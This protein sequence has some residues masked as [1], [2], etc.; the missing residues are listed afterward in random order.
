MATQFLTGA[1]GCIGAWVLREL[2]ARGD[3]VVAF[4]LST[5]RHRIDAVLEPGQ[6][7]SIRHIEGDVSDPDAIGKAIESSRPAGIIHLA[8]M[9]VPSCKADP[10]RGA[11]VNVVGTLNV[12]EA[13]RA[14]GCGRVVYASSAAVY[15]PPQG[16]PDHAFRE[17]EADDARTHYGVF[18]QA[19]EGA[20]RVFWHDHGLSTVGLR[21]LTVYGV[22]R[23]FGLTS[24]PTTA[25]KAALLG[26]PY[27][28]GFTGP[29]DF[30]YV[31]DIAQIFVRCLAETPDGAHIYNPHGE[32]T[33]VS[34]IVE[35]I[36]RIVPED[37][38]GLVTCDGPNLPIPGNMSDAS[39]AAAM[40]DIPRT[41]LEEGLR[42][43]YE[44]FGA[45]NDAG[46]LDLRDLPREEV[47]R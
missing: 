21:P 45:L 28:I 3:E 16:D 17:D 30:Q 19:N 46:R 29:T 6:Q 7:A 36:D 9:Q 42:R 11:M 25:L 2:V 1:C 23:D 35:L 44:A 8:G 47:A 10:V 22:G 34:R 5:E 20:A 39:L 13:A 38:R 26:R 14:A 33:D 32:S 31:Q 18:K 37:R 4:D 12:F 27:R 15:G 43:T 40:D 41:P 24:G